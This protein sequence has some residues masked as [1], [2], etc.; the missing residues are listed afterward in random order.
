MQ[1]GWGEGKF[2]LCTFFS[3]FENLNVDKTILLSVLRQSL[4]AWAL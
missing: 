3:T 4:V 2:A 1:A